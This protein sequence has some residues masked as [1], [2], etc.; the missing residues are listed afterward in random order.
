MI[1]DL[2]YVS[3]NW[4]SNRNSINKEQSWVTN[5]QKF[6]NEELDEILS[7]FEGYK[8]DHSRRE[9]LENLIV[10]YTEIMTLVPPCC[11]KCANSNDLRLIKSTNQNLKKA[12]NKIIY[13]KCGNEFSVRYP[14]SGLQS[15]GSFIIY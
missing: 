6:I 8:E 11:S 13:T 12:I 4:L 14:N 5:N 15:D 9:F 2:R 10:I 1:I 7:F 3:F